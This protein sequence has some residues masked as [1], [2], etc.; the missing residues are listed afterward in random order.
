MADII[1]EKLKFHCIVI[2]LIARDNFTEF[3]YHNGFQ[4]QRIINLSLLFCHFMD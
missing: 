4:S 1:H 2:E 3:S